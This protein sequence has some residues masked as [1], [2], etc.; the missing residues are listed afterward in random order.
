MALEG[1]LSDFGLADILQLIS[2]QRKTGVLTLEGKMDKVKLM[3]ID[4]NV[5]GAESKRR[6]EDN[7]L[8]KILLKKGHLK[9][10]QLKA[11]LEE[12]RKS[13]AKLGSILIK[14]ELVD[15]EVVNE[16][17]QGQVTETVIQLFGWKQGTYEFAAQAVLGDRDLPCC[18]DTQHLL[19]EGL[20][21]VDE[22]TLIQ[23]K[24]TLDTVFRKT[25]ETP[26][27]LT[28]E[29]TE[30]FSFVDGEN[31]A[32][33]IIDLSGQDNFEVSKTL[34]SLMEKGFIETAVSAPVIKEKHAAEKKPS[35]IIAGLFSY[36]AV[37]LS[38]CLSLAGVLTQRSFDFKNFTASRQIDELRLKIESFGLEHSQ[39]PS[40]IDQVTES[41]DA[42]GRP[43][44][45]RTTGDSF[46]IASAGPDGVKDTQDDIY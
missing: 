43:Y 17:L 6:M 42:W 27:G 3:F 14:M 15:K 9:E 7:R 45:Y 11:A 23:G 41:K 24:I 30:V 39:Y 16:I 36:A 25:G 19:M 46:Y 21:I 35:L 29:E 10:G 37:I 13:R 4:G 40:T 26:A 38:V 22:W 31:D 44:I 18:L 34:L 8:G 32:S 5:A 33:T 1:A 2:F 28:N 20:R 12:Q